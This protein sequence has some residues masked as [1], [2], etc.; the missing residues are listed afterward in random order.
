M[1]PKRV[2]ITRS[3]LSDGA[4]FLREKG[5][6]VDIN[7]EDRP[8]S[9]DELAKIAG[10]YDA[11]ITVLSD[12]IDAAFL[13]ANAHLKI[14]ANYAVG[15]NNI[16]VNAARSLGIAVTNTPD[17]LTEATAETALG[18]MLAASRNFYPASQSVYNGQWKT[19]SP[20]GHLGP[21]LKGKTLGVVGLGRIGRRLAEMAHFAFQM[22]VLYTAHSPKETPFNAQMVGLDELCKRSDYI[23][24]H[25]PL[26]EE[27]KGLIGKKEFALMKDKAVLVNTARGEV[28]DQNA[29][30]EALK[31]RKIFAAGLDVMTPEPLPHESELLRLPNVFLLPHIGSATFEARREMALLC[32]EN[33]YAG[34]TN[35]KLLSPVY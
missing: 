27:T 32:A 1:V 28:V 24:V 20:Q 13:Q 21:A 29:L 26:N 9:K 2:F 12:Q 30:I 3:L 4:E 35:Q 5:L 23:S 19:W 7:A 11:L 14:I 6:K 16:D 18:L 33:V 34:L 17:V 22:P 15:F 25:V 31:D 10:Q 8:L